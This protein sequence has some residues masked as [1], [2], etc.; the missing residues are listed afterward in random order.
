M[1]NDTYSVGLLFAKIPRKMVRPVAHFFGKLKDFL[2]RFLTH[3][4]V[5][6]QPPADR[7]YWNIEFAGQI[8][9]GYFFPFIHTIGYNASLKLN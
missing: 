7:C 8:V 5:I 9:Y 6:F 4:R 1:D 3:N 2:S